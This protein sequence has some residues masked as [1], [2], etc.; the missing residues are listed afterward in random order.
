MNID[1]FL[2]DI[3]HKDETDFEQ[4][5]GERYLIV[6]SI[7]DFLMTRQGMTVVVHREF[8]LNQR[9]VTLTVKKI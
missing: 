2:I 8:L 6:P 3:F 9:K 5:M 1:G 7:G 4:S